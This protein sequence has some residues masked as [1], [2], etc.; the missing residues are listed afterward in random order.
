[1]KSCDN[2]TDKHPYFVCSIRLTYGTSTQANPSWGSVNDVGAILS[3][4][5]SLN[6]SID[7]FRL[8]PPYPYEGRESQEI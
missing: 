8:N 6:G 4:P 2:Q 1:M 3:S 7:A 5:I